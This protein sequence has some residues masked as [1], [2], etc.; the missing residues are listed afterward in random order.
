MTDSYKR[1]THQKRSGAVAL[2]LAIA[3]LIF[4][5]SQLAGSPDAEGQPP[6]EPLAVPST[7]NELPPPPRTFDCDGLR[8]SDEMGDLPAWRGEAA[9]VA[10]AGGSEVLVGLPVGAPDG[11]F[12]ISAESASG[13][14][15]AQFSMMG[16][17]W[18]AE[19]HVTS[20]ARS[21]MDYPPHWGFLVQ[22]PHPGCWTVTIESGG[23]VDT[24]VVP[25]SN[26]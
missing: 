12:Q 7:A 24:V 6:S 10:W 11:G 13:D 16:D 15:V 5:A 22:F 23:I 17:N 14:G 21:A 19:L 18:E 3:A 20:G 2:V 1:P 4:G 8:H 25:V 9:H 26:P